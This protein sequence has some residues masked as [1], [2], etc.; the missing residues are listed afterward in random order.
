MESLPLEVLIEIL[1]HLHPHQ[2][3]LIRTRLSKPLTATLA[4]SLGPAFPRSN[5]TSLLHTASPRPP[6]LLRKI[7]WDRLDLAYSVSL[8]Q[9]KGFT[10]SSA[11]ILLGGLEPMDTSYV[12]APPIHHHKRRVTGVVR[13][14]L[15]EALM[16]CLTGTGERGTVFD[17]SLDSHFALF[18]MASIDRPQEL[19]LLISHLCQMSSLHHPTTT[20]TDP[21]LSKPRKVH[22]HLYDPSV[23]DDLLQCACS[24]GAIHVVQHLLNVKTINPTR[25]RNL[26]LRVTVEHGH[27]NCLNLLLSHPSVD[28]G[29]LNNYAVRVAAGR[30]HLSVL[31]RLL[32]DPRVDPTVDQNSPL[33]M[34]IVHHHLEAVTLLL[35]SGKVN[36][37]A[38]RGVAFREALTSD[39][40]SFKTMTRFSQTV[41]T[42]LI[43]SIVE[44]GNLHHLTSILEDLPNLPLGFSDSLLLRIAV[45]QNHIR[46]VQ[47]LLDRN[48]I[49]PAAMRHRAVCDA[50]RLGRV[51]ALQVL[52]R[53]P[54]ADK[55]AN[56][57]FPARVA[58]RFG[59]LK[60][61]EMVGGVVEGGDGED[62]FEERDRLLEEEGDCFY[63]DGEDEFEEMDRALEEAWERRKGC[64]SSEAF[65]SLFMGVDEFEETDCTL[66]EEEMRIIR[67]DFVCDEV[68]VKS[69]GYS[70]KA[71][72]ECSA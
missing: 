64:V 38:F 53:D 26:A 19:N 67:G 52:L 40:P 20:M 8:I 7:R 24:Y 25:G 1:V 45:R 47:L 2:V 43:I 12:P 59:H 60:V 28:P 72:S 11:R 54:R 27:L 56:E 31:Q 36:P 4:Q 70:S 57:G 62:E 21:P 34:A 44:N 66:E 55:V 29:D 15:V 42:N 3:H 51:E 69:K 58:R 5:L 71:H 16:R 9:A 48:G 61:L 63:D 18:W 46:L 22:S 68:H 35:E 39:F 30:G 6:L 32:Q 50:A 10:R 23:L 65:P 49:D 33:I 13:D 37:M 41:P 17:P 14:R